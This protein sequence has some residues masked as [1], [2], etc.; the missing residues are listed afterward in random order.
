MYI[1]CIVC[2]KRINMLPYAE[3]DIHWWGKVQP[4]TDYW[5]LEFHEVYCGP[6]CSLK[7]HENRRNL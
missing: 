4:D 5:N 1:N 7:A 6:V 3:V 2:G